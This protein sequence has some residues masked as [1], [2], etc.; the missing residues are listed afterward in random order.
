MACTARGWRWQSG[1]RGYGAAP[2]WQPHWGDQG[3]RVVI[4][5][6]LGLHLLPTPVLQQAEAMVL[7]ASFSR[8][9]P[10]GAG[11]RG[12]RVALEGMA[13]QLAEPD[14]ARAMLQTFLAR[15]ADPGS[16]PAASKPEPAMTRHSGPVDGPLGPLQLQR[17]QQDLELLARC[18][19]LPEGFPRSI[20]VMT[21][22]GSDDRIVVPQARE[23]LQRDLE[24]QGC[25]L[26]QLR[27][28]GAGHRLQHPQVIGAVLEWL[29]TLVAP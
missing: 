28:A 18:E 22:D 15:A 20:P 27:L 23:Q 19:G 14:S 24:S 2:P 10:E 25:P 6:S 5:H 7:L 1:E 9:V 8:F 16:T 21:V 29:Q 26:H 3:L 4:A 13:A 11:G 17:L 12:L